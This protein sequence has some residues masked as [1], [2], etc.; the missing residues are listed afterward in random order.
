MDIDNRVGTDCR[1]GEYGCEGG[2]DNGEQWGKLGQLQ[3]NN[4]K[5]KK[6]HI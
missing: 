3:Q 2:Q 6:I 5:I 4:S 1:S